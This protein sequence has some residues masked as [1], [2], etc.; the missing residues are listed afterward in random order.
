MTHPLQNQLR[1]TV[2]LV[3]SEIDIRE[4]E[5]Q[6]LHLATVIGIDDAGAGID[7]VFR[8]ETAAGGDTAV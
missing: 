4:V 1:N 3:D 2:T 7:E 6:H 8:G 5:Q